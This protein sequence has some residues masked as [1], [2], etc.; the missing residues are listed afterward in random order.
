MFSY[1]LYLSKEL[2]KQASEFT[3]RLEKWCMIPNSTV[4]PVAAIFKSKLLKMATARK[5]SHIFVIKWKLQV[6]LSI[7]S[8]H[9]YTLLM[10]QK[11]Q[12]FEK[13]L[14]MRLKLSSAPLIHVGNGCDIITRLYTQANILMVSFIF[15]HVYSR[16][17]TTVC[18]STVPSDITSI[19]KVG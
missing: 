4:M 17:L 16:D 18:I 10:V 11:S 3:S 15:A 2:H 5:K 19:L 8:L 7:Q 12:L 1:F 14:G 13:K 9:R 6:R